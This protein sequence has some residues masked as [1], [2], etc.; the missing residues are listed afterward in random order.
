[1]KLSDFTLDVLRGNS[2][3][4]KCQGY[5][6]IWIGFLKDAFRTDAF[7]HHLPSLLRNEVV[8]ELKCSKNIFSLWSIL[9]RGSP[10]VGNEF[11]NLALRLSSQSL[12]L[13][14]LHFHFTKLSFTLFCDDNFWNIIS[15]RS[16]SSIASY[17]RVKSSKVM[18]F[19]CPHV[20]QV[21]MRLISSLFAFHFP[22]DFPSC[23]SHPRM[24]PKPTS[25]LFYNV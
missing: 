10:Q 22:F 23:F 20:S 15:L 2:I 11:S 8:Q 13:V 4:W 7:R 1:M 16:C 6:L 3:E 21:G 18:T 5:N 25:W 24:K 19:K 9:S 17:R 14:L 12:V